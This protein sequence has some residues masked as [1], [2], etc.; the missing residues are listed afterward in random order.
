MMNSVGV[1]I[2]ET[3][4][5]VC[6]GRCGKSVPVSN[7]FPGPWR[8]CKRDA[9]KKSGD[10]KFWS[11]DWPVLALSYLIAYGARLANHRIRSPDLPVPVSLS[12]NCRA[13]IG[14]CTCQ[15][16]LTRLHS[17]RLCPKSMFRYALRRVLTQ[18][19][20]GFK[21]APALFQSQPWHY[22]HRRIHDS[23]SGLPRID[24]GASLLSNDTIYAL[25]SGSGRAGIAVIRIS[26]PGCLDVCC[27]S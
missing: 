26:G 24:D 9:E 16:S 2:D 10:S 12:S 8:G 20:R 25:S 11:R 23:R 6:L 15:H 13:S 4:L 22:P 7:R 18:R 14:S 17:S 21:S 27:C 19:Q 3:R 1:C 5:G